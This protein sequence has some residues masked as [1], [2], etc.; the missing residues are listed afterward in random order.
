MAKFCK[1]CGTEVNIEAKYCPKC[2]ASTSEVTQNVD[3]NMNYNNVNNGAQVVN[4]GLPNEPYAIPSFVLSIISF[5]CCSFLAFPGLILGI[6]ALNNMK[7]KKSNENQK[8]FVIA[9]LVMSGISIA[10]FVLSLIFNITRF[11]DLF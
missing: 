5:F 1:Y 8:G 3:N 9:A 10:W 2:G 11:G 4:N 6:M 7:A